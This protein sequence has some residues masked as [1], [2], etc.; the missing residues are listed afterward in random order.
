MKQGGVGGGGADR[1]RGRRKERETE[2]VSRFTSSR[3]ALQDSGHN[4]A[5]VWAPQLSAMTT[6]S[7]KCTHSAQ[8]GSLFWL[9]FMSAEEREQTSG[10]I[11]PTMHYKILH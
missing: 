5:D 7:S 4:D 1:R 8:N 6:G 10:T 9:N 2:A 3:P 11:F